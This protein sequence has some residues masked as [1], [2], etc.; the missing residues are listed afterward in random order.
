MEK[1]NR[2]F[3]LDLTG[4]TPLFGDCALR[5]RRSSGMEGGDTVTNLGLGLVKHEWV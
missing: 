1:F 2:H 5:P 4:G 3:G